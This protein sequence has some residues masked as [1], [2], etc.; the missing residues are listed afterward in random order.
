MKRRLLALLLAVLTL[1]ML[2]AAAFAAFSDQKRLAME[3]SSTSTSGTH[4]VN[5]YSGSIENFASANAAPAS[6]A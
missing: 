3:E 6:A 5:T 1:T 4:S 2:T